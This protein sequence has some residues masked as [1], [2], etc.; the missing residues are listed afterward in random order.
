MC[1]TQLGI[2]YCLGLTKLALTKQAG[3]VWL[4]VQSTQVWKV[5]TM[6]SALITCWSSSRSICNNVPTCNISAE[7]FSC[8]WIRA[9]GNCCE[10]LW[11]ITFGGRNESRFVS[12]TPD[13]KIRPLS[14]ISSE[15][16]KSVVEKATGHDFKRITDCQRIKKVGDAIA[17]KRNAQHPHEI[18]IKS[19]FGL[20]RLL[21][22]AD[23]SLIKRLNPFLVAR[24]LSDE[25]DQWIKAPFVM[26][27][28]P[29][30]DWTL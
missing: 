29:Q 22:T 28:S 19:P 7:S 2:I 30:S 27:S 6:Y 21:K 23:K 17:G 12:L 4:A 13:Q 5:L 24:S 9:I 14:E 3:I 20:D 25:I 26:N 16:T 18:L 11:S 8:N 10:R 15:I 1:R